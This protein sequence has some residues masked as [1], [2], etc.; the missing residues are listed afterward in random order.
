MLGECIICRRDSHNPT[1]D[2]AFKEWMG[3]MYEYLWGQDSSSVMSSTDWT[4]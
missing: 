2:I 1:E 3:G 4:L